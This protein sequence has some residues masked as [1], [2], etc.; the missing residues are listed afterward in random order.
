MLDQV[1]ANCWAVCDAKSLGICMAQATPTTAIRECAD[2]VRAED[3]CG[4]WPVLA[5]AS[6]R[7]VERMAERN[8][9]LVQL[10]VKKGVRSRGSSSGLQGNET[11]KR[12]RVLDGT[13]FRDLE[14]KLHESTFG[15]SLVGPS[16][17]EQRI[18]SRGAGISDHLHNDDGSGVSKFDQKLDS[19][20]TGMK[21]GRLCA[22]CDL[23]CGRCGVGCCVG[24]CCRSD[25]CKAERCRSESWCTENTLDESPEDG[26]QKHHGGRTGCVGGG[27]FGVCGIE[28][29]SGWECKTCVAH[30]SAQANKCVAK[31]RPVLISSWLPQVVAVE[32]C[33]D[34]NVA[35]FSLEFECLHDGQGPKRQNCELECDNG[36]KRGWRE[37][38]TMDGNGP[39]VDTLAQ[40]GSQMDREMQYERVDCHQ[41]TYAQLGW[42]CGQNGV[43]RNL[44]DGLGMP[45]SSMV[46]META[47][48]ERSGERKIFWPTPAAFQNLQVGGHGGDRGF[49]IH[50][51]RRRFVGIWLHLA[52][53]RVSWRQF[54]K[55]GKSS[56]GA[57]PNAS[58]TQVRPA[59]RGL[60]LMGAGGI[61]WSVWRRKQVMASKMDG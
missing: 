34:Y 14:W 7:I 22:G 36:G 5:V 31:W 41:R 6:C 57:W 21:T 54:A 24:C 12:E 13:D 40:D 42:S 56:V 44:C 59:W 30:R 1:Q 35:G 61:E 25:G 46:E 16:S 51:K 38:A 18:A 17:N 55:F 47:P 9:W 20:E 32:H 39:V 19:P 10:D 3:A 48:L 2:G 8:L 33:K 27:S 26:G 49:Q 37:E 28:G 23:L 29:V 50:W 60:M 11:T 52:Q 4:C 58:G 15:N 43:Q 53:K 45:R